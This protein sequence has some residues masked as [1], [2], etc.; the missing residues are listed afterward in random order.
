MISSIRLDNFV[1]RVYGLLLY[2]SI[3]WRIVGSWRC[4]TKLSEGVTNK[5]SIH[6]LNP[7]CGASRDWDFAGEA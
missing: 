5:Y 4:S 7:P 2:N 1:L 6:G 3:Q